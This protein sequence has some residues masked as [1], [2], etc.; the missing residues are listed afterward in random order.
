M[1]VLRVGVV[2]VAVLG[3]LLLAEP[4]ARAE[5][6]EQRAKNEAATRFS[7][8]IK[9]YEAGDYAAALAEFEAAH[10]TVP[11]YQ[12]L[13]N[14]GITQKRL[15]RYGEALHTLKRYLR[16]GGGQISSERRSTVEQEIVEVQKLVAEISIHVAGNPAEIDV[17]GQPVGRTPLAEPVLVGPGR[18]MVRARRD[19]D[20]PAEQGIEAISGARLEITLAP[21]SRM[22]T[23]SSAR[24]SIASNPGGAD[25]F[26]D[27]RLSG[28]TP[29]EGTVEPGGHEVVAQF[30]GYEK[31]R[32]EVLLT[33]G[34]T[35]N[36]MIDLLPQ[37]DVVLANH[38]TE[39]SS[40]GSHAFYKRWYF[41]TAVV[42]VVAAGTATA[43]VLSKRVTTDVNINYN[44]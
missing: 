6:P 27:G 3:G 21:R 29:W 10:R 42:G 33:P 38:G 20:E 36:L 7:R 9:L 41:W 13:F 30:A 31:A 43:V 32:Q 28:I 24:L 23:P 39:P 11:R 44:P 34:Q 26:I 19:G 12:V 4:R 35:R 17:D 14:I 22:S 8:G 5:D 25:L 2:V 37:H 40:G 1:F 18:H 16:E 15:F